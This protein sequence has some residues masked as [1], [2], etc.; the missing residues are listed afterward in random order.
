MDA[1][2]LA[3]FLEEQATGV[4]AMAADDTAY[5]VPVSFAYDDGPCLYFRLGLRAGSE[6]EAFLEAA[7]AARFVVYDRTD[8]GWK[9]VIA[10]GR[11]VSLSDSALDGSVVQAVEQLQIPYYH[12]PPAARQ[13]AR[14]R[15]RPPRRR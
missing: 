1:L 10:E 9:S 4:L 14:L 15:H 13:R 11:L 2:E 5:A 6:K 7:D 12:G 8:G 3:A